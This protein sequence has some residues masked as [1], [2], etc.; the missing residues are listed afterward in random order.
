MNTLGEER[1]LPGLSIGL[2]LGKAR[3]VYKADL[4]IALAGL[5][6]TASQVGALLLLS[7]GSAHSSVEVS[8][9]LDVDSGFVARVIER[10]ESQRLVRRTRDSED[11][12][13][14]NLALTGTGREIAE[15]AA[16]IVPVVL[17]RR[18]SA[19]DEPELVTFCRLLGKLL[20]Q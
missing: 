18:L 11:R 9:L 7:H 2:A 3:S 4:D 14:V 8:R 13:V 5:G 15:C 6:V 12:R 17:N 10:L 19:F 16:E 20:D 1:M